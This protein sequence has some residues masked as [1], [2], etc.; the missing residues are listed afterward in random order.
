MFPGCVKTVSD[1]L[2]WMR[3]GAHHWEAHAAVP[4]ALAKPA[5]EALV[6]NEGGTQKRGESPEVQ[7]RGDGKEAGEPEWGSLEK[8]RVGP[9]TRAVNP[10]RTIPRQF[11]PY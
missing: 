10:R 4:V 9:C 1:E 3:T 7:I 6:R 11:Q 2:R 8:E 5:P